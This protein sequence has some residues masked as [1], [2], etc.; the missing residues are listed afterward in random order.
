M[1]Q[2]NILFFCDFCLILPFIGIILAF[3]STI[4]EFDTNILAISDIFDNWKTIPFQNIIISNKNCSSIGLYDIINYYW[5]G[6]EEGCFCSYNNVTYKGRCSEIQIRKNCT[7]VNE[8]YN[9][10][11]NKWKNKFI[12]G[13]Y[14]KFINNNNNNNENKNEKNQ[15]INKII[16]TY[17]EFNKINSSQL[18]PFKTKKCGIIDTLNNSLCIPDIEKCPI[19]YININNSNNNNNF[20]LI[21]NNKE[22]ENGKIYTNF[23]LSEDKICINHYLK[24]FIHEYNY[25]LF[26][27]NDY[28]LKK[29]SKFKKNKTILI[30]DNNFKILDFY[31]KNSFYLDNNLIIDLPFYPKI[32][33]NINLFTNVYTGWKK[34]CETKEFYNFFNNQSNAFNEIYDIISFDNNYKNSLLYNILILSCLFFFGIFIIK[35]K[36]ILINNKIEINFCKLFIIYFIY[37]LIMGI[38][39]IFIKISNINLIEINKAKISNDFFE[40]VYNNDCSDKNTNFVFKFI[41]EQYFNYKNKYYN[42]RLLGIYEISYCL[43][44]MGY[45][46][47]NKI[48]N[49]KRKKRKERQKM[50]Y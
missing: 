3:F 46:Y 1:H 33:S 9:V 50:F 17:F 23:L 18:C 29:C 28:F 24:N 22:T 45:L 20:N 34:K 16:T 36:L 2:K 4:N 13:Q 7:I 47:I 5:P 6:T 37:V 38:N 26:K 27:S 35:Y 39:V 19:N 44:I 12:C 40:I 15:I 11:L 42:I 49:D 43:I 31:S 21:V 14:G 10:S 25:P 41:A 30:N 8:K 32:E 48:N